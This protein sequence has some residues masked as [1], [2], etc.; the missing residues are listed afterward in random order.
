MNSVNNAVLQNKNNRQNELLSDIT[1]IVES[2][3]FSRD[4]SINIVAEQL[5]M[6]A[7]YLGKVFKKASGKS[8]SE[9]ALSQRM[10]AAC[11]MLKETD[12]TIDE[13]VYSVGFGDTPYFYKLFKKLNGCTS[14]K[15]RQGNKSIS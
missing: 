10:E 12:M 5:G 15:Y 1:R 13:I 11:K 9:F 8:F 7:A 4:F 2:N 3:C 14:V 6:S